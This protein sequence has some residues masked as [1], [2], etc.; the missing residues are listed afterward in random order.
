MRAMATGTHR[1]RS[2]G[3]RN[4]RGYGRCNILSSVV[5]VWKILCAFLIF[6]GQLESLVLIFGIILGCHNVYI[7]RLC[8][9]SGNKKLSQLSP[10]SKS[11][12]KFIANLN[13]FKTTMA[14][15]CPQEIRSTNRIRLRRGSGT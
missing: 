15:V 5:S 7:L 4:K 1:S 3:W 9:Y 12:Q 14:P 10:I 6:V 8:Y 13:E 2:S 11:M